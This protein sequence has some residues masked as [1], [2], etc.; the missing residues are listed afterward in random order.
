MR[1]ECVWE[2]TAKERPLTSHSLE[3]NWSADACV[4]GGGITGLSTAL[5]LAQKGFSVIVLEAGEVADG[6]SGKNV[7]LVNPGLWIPPED[8]TR[9]L[10]E[11]EGERANSILGAA[12]ETVFGLIQKF[13]I[14]CDATTTG[15]LHCAHNQTGVRELE[16]RHQQ[17][18]RRGYPVELVT[19]TECRNITGMAGVPAALLDHRAGTVNPLAYT[20]GLA[21]AATSLGVT[22][23]QH[24]AVEQLER[25]GDQWLVSTGAATV[26]AGSV[27]LAT[28]AYTE[29]GWNV[30]KKHFFPG[31]FYQ[32]ASKPL[33]EELT[34]SVLPGN[35][36]SWDTRSVLSSI[37]KDCEGRLILGSLGRGET[38]PKHFVRS[39]AN[40]IQRHYFPQLNGIE[41]DMSWTGKI[42][43]TPDHMIRVFSPAKDLYAV[44]GYNGRGITTG[45][46]M[47]KGL[48][49]LIVQGTD[50]YLPV[51]VKPVDPI[52]GISLRAIAYEAGFTLY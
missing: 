29:S 13:A 39:W 8:I 45:S 52:T 1:D 20:R 35:Q 19:G 18:T 38:K 36:G 7:G 2:V 31:H 46:V 27:V 12:T 6:G 37:R 33:S 43:F 34:Q 16:R 41:W 14:A 4:I 50:E 22:I 11:S 3:V 21:R 17:F 44:T 5:H 48:A 24:S 49:E 40:R 42:G 25:V 28:N 47:G 15:T 10:G 9:T 26:R 23:A 30:V 32:V 51:P